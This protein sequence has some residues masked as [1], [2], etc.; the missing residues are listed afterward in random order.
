MKISA[1][2]KATENIKYFK[3]PFQSDNYSW[4]MLAQHSSQWK[5]YRELSSEEKTAFFDESAPV[6]HRSTLKAHFSGCQEVT[7]FYA[8]KG[9]V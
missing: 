7:Y 3:K 8:D 1:K 4:H 5:A 6:P 9:I 2:C